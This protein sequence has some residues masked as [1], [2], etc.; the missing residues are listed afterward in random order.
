MNPPERKME[1]TCDADIDREGP[2]PRKARFV[3]TMSILDEDT[4]THVAENGDGWAKIFL[5]VLEDA[6]NLYER[7]ALEL[8]DA[9]K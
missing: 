9:Y 6:I 4:A 3:I 5:K 8:P 7:Q 2:Y 1:F